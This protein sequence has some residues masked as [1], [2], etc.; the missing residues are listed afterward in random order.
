M[1][2][3]QVLRKAVGGYPFPLTAINVW[4]MAARTFRL[5]DFVTLEQTEI[6]LKQNSLGLTHTQPSPG[7][8]CPLRTGRHEGK[9]CVELPFVITLLWNEEMKFGH[10]PM[11]EVC[12]KEY[13]A[14]AVKGSQTLSAQL[15]AHFHHATT[16]GKASMVGKKGNFSRVIGHPE[17]GDI[18]GYFTEHCAHFGTGGPKL[19]FS[20][21]FPKTLL[22]IL[23]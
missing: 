7:T 1:G 22:K 8:T 10:T 5:K 12:W 17:A 13:G 9:T 18:L 19:L 21:L 3:F 23:S 4:V 15:Q 11:L 16:L 20:T 6:Y 14:S 2:W